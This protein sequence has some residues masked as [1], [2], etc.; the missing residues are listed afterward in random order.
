MRDAGAKLAVEFRDQAV[1]RGLLPEVRRPFTAD[2]RQARARLT[3]RD[4]ASGG[5]RAPLRLHRLHRVRRLRRRALSHPRALR[6]ASEEPKEETKEETKEEPKD[7]AS[8]AA[9]PEKPAEPS[10]PSRAPPTR[11]FPS[12]RSR[13]RPLRRRNVESA[14]AIADRRA[15]PTGLLFAQAAS[16]RPAAACAS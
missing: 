14:N 7:E 3:R 13:P 6:R 1:V 16:L 11:K 9:E 4:S 5:D 8:E 2:Q 10:K 15:L 12:S